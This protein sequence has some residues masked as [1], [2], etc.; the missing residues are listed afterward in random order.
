MIKTLYY[1]QCFPRFNSDLDV[2]YT[3]ERFESLADARIALDAARDD[4][5]VDCAWIER[6]EVEI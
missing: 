2:E 3:G 5:N 4:N 1:I 6:E